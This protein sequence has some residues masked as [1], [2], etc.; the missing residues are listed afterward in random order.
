MLN[1]SLAPKFWEFDQNNS[2]GSFAVD[3]ERGIGPSV[4][5][6]AIDRDHAISRAL[7]I[8]IYFDG[9]ADGRDCECC[10]DRWSE[11]WGNGLER[12]EACSQFSFMWHD[13]VYVH[14]IDGEIIRVSKTATSD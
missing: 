4:W 3:D 14:M 11:P 6:E 12:P 13:T 9:C 1:P 5:I 8:G 10:G 2:G 7:A